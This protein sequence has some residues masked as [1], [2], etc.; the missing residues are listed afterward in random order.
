MV[1]EVLLIVILVD[2]KWLQVIEIVIII[3]SLP[4]NN[5]LI[6]FLLCWGRNIGFRIGVQ[7]VDHLVIV[8]K[9]VQLFD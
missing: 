4:F 6:I 2:Y 3:G 7:S 1:Q 9:L 5:L 8:L